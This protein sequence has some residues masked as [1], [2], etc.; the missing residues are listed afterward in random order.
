M[1]KRFKYF[2]Q[3]FLYAVLSFSCSIISFEELDIS[4]NVSE[5]QM[6]FDGSE[7]KINF[8]ILPDRQAAESIMSVK[9][10]D[11]VIDARI[12]WNNTSCI[13]EPKEGFKRNSTY[14][15]S[16]NGKIKTSDNRYYETKFERSFIY[17]ISNDF[18]LLT[19]FMEPGD[20]IQNPDDVLELIFNKPV[21]IADFENNFSITPFIQVKKT[22]EDGNTKVVIT[23]QTKWPVNTFFTWTLRDLK[24]SDGYELAE[25]KSSTF[26]PYEDLEQCR[27]LSVCGAIVS[28][29]I[30]PQYTLKT[31]SSSI[32]GSNSQPSSSTAGNSQPSAAQ[33]PSA[34]P[35]SALFYIDGLS[36]N[37]SI[38]F[39]FNKEIELSSFKNLFSITPAV[40]GSF[41]QD[42]KTV[43]FIPD[44]GFEISA[45]YTILIPKS[46]K[47]KNSLPLHDDS[48][49]SFTPVNDFLKVTQISLADKTSVDFYS[50]EINSSYS[51]AGQSENPNEIPAIKVSD[52]D[53][54]FAEISFSTGISPDFITKIEQAVTLEAVFPL[55][56]KTPKLTEIKWNDSHTKA[57]LKYEGFSYSQDQKYI[58]RLKINS[59]KS[60]LK[61]ENG[62]YMKED[63]WTVFSAE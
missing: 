27:L 46:V 18:F 15:I 40:K 49:I 21:D 20:K 13:I 2:I 39:T 5:N 9:K 38:A 55:F 62:G 56:I 45:D 43:I 8:S 33:Q 48:I 41:I 14:R 31:Q 23:P 3:L 30:E 16:I 24:S 63:I 29:L 36:I 47:D 59:S 34:K 25:E 12:I 42:E 6:Y 28:D 32:A 22:Y 35:T 7:V 4:S 17:G 1:L 19:S 54:L 60:L 57:T 26:Y 53:S 52:F 11:S 50:G 51:T 61:S 10:N 44:D 58:Y 37:D